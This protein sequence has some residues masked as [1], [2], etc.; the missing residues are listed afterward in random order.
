MGAR[1]DA[2]GALSN[3]PQL[4][5]TFTLNQYTVTFESDWRKAKAL[6]LEILVTRTKELE[7]EARKR[8]DRAAEDLHIKFT[9]LTPVVWTN[10]APEGVRL[11]MRYLCKPRER[12]ASATT[13]WE[14]VLDAFANEPGIDL[15]YPTTRFFDNVVEGK[16]KAR[17]TE[18][19]GDVPR[20]SRVPTEPEI[21]EATEDKA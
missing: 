20:G 11:T 4:E 15:A 9:T 19:D 6:L 2:H 8:I 14:A 17:A 7:P 21:I 16:P 5:V 13:I 12:R 10:L 1:D 18:E 3:R